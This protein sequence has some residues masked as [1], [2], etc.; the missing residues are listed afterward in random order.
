[1]AQD[2]RVICDS[3]ALAEGGT[4]V[5]FALGEGERAQT[6]FAIRHLGSVHAFVNRCPHMGTELDWQPGEFFEA[7]G[8]YLVCAT[9]GALFQPAT[10][11]CVA[12]PCK[13]AHLERLRTREQNGRVLLLNHSDPARAPDE[14]R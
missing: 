11:F 6:G 3:T 5:R 8:V 9:H 12:G 4:G 7:S 10:G 1:M 2:E 13:G 14:T